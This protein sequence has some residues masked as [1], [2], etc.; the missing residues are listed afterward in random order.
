MTS[1]FFKGVKQW[2]M[3]GEGG[4]GKL[5]CFYYDN[6]AFTAIYT[7]STAKVRNLLPKSQMNPVELMPGKCLVSFTAFEYRETDIDPYNEFSV[8]FLITYNKPQIPGITAGW[9][10]MRR[11]F[12]AYVWKLPVT[13]EIARYGGVELYGYPKFI[14]DIDFIPE[15]SSISC[16]LSEGGNHILTLKGKVLPTGRGKV[17]RYTTYSVLEDIPLVA[18]VFINPVEHVEVRDKAAATLELGPEHDIANALRE[19]DLSPAPI[20]YQYS[21]K[22]EAILFGGRNLMD[23]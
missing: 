2:P 19:I 3:E 20:T 16:E 6:T 21:P 15:E 18:N 12:H 11:H 9:Q 22:T 1:E 14:A 8:A 23:D 7:A 4:S 17:T 13:T 5:P 10:M